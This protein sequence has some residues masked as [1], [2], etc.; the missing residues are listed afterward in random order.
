MQ[1]NDSGCSPVHVESHDCALYQ[2]SVRATAMIH[3]WA[4]EIQQA[5][6]ELAH[7]KLAE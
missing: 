5:Q 4:A 3:Q 2:G 1:S 6:F 7:A